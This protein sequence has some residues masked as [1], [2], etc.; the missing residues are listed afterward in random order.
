MK[1]HGKKVVLVPMTLEEV[2]QF[3][4]WAIRS[5][6]WYGKY[7]DEPIPTYE[8]FRKDLGDHYFD[9]SQPEMGRSFA[10]VVNERTVGQV[11]YNEI[12]RKDQS[13]DIDIIVYREE[14]RGK[15]Y[16]T[17]ALWTLC[18]Y[19]FWEM[20]LAKVR[21]ETATNNER[22]IK[23]YEKI[24]FRKVDTYFSKDVEFFKMEVTR[25]S[26]AKSS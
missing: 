4:Y 14:D 7:S 18:K 8:E 24:G 3:F 23:S 11:N 1:L 16:G 25:E 5:P 21:L 22:A 12:D 9:G 17:D 15:G 19:L 2:P 20:G 13:V 26:F 10:V 6:F